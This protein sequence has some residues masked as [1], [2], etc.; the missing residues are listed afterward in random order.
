MTEV[1][2]SDGDLQALADDQLDPARRAEVE[3]HVAANPDAARTV[4]VYR[5]QNTALHE[6]YDG[7]LNEPVPERFL[8]T[9]RQRRGGG[10]IRIAAA[11]VLFVLGGAGGWWLNDLAP[12][13]RAALASQ[14]SERARIAHAVYVPEVRHPVEV[15]AAEQGHLTA[16][17]TKRIGAQLIVPELT[18]AGYDL[19]GGRLL[20]GG[21]TPA[22]QIMYEDQSGARLTLYIRASGPDDAKSALRYDRA[23]GVGVYYW[24]DGEKGYALAGELQKEPLLKVAKL[25]YRQLNR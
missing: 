25:V 6:A 14:V 22:A 18:S 19:M 8:R 5:A 13:S 12:P 11:L 4:A 15:T 21:G 20:P 2:I 1:P 24:D 17:L 16:W 9:H 10:L 3:A 23:A 7:A